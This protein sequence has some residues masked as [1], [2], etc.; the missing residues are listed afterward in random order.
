M[1]EALPVIRFFAWIDLCLGLFLCIPIIGPTLIQWVDGFLSS[2]PLLI[3]HYHLVLFNLLGLMVLLWA[4]ARIQHTAIWQLKYDCFGR[5]VV[6]AYLSF[7]YCQGMP[8]LM[9]FIGIELLGL[10]QLKYL[11]V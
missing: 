11:K 9:L 7:Y 4:L 1:K 6:L 8:V 3:N 2:T 5:L 10:Y